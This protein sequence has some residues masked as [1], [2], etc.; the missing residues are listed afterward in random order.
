MCRHSH[1]N[2]AIFKIIRK[3]DF[4]VDK[5]VADARWA[6]SADDLVGEQVA[7]GLEVAIGAKSI[8]DQGP[9]VVVVAS[10]SPVTGVEDLLIVDPEDLGHCER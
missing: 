2:T 10:N 6:E 3:V 8:I 1:D 9:S 5:G 7:E 4:G